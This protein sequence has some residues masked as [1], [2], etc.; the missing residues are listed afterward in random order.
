MKVILKQ[1]IR[2]LGARGALVDVA[3][4][5]ARNYLLPRGLA[6]PATDGNLK[7]RQQR[8]T[9]QKTKTEKLQDTAQSLASKL[10]GLSITVRARTGEG[11]RLFGSV[12]AQ[13]IAQGIAAVA[14]LS[15]DRRKI[16]LQETIKTTGN[17][18]VLLRLRPEVSVSVEVRV[19]PE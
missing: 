5:Y 9:V 12:T 2:D 16:E 3:D 7:Q 11:G 10:E 8:I 15:V 17:Y 13:D 19:V 6:M 1:D 18:R 14:G 4:G